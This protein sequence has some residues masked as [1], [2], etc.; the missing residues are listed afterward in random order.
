MGENG[1]EEDDH[2]YYAVKCH[3]ISIWYEIRINWKI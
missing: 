1:D 2:F 3:F